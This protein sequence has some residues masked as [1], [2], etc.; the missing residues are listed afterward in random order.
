MINPLPARVPRLRPEQLTDEQRRLYEELLN[1][2]RAQGPQY[3]ELTDADGVLTGPF[4]AML[5]SPRVGTVLQR[6]GVELRYHTDLPDQIRELV[7]LVVAASLGSDFE[8]Y[9]H[10]SLAR[11]YGV[12]DDAIIAL[13]ERRSPTLADPAQGAAYGL[14]VALLRGEDIPDERYYAMVRALGTSG[15]F[16]VSAIVGYY[17]LLAAQL[18]LFRVGLQAPVAGPHHPAP[19]GSRTS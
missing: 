4:N 14:A 8:W 16:D 19:Q 12:D 10:E 13:R 2:P 1:G 11:H 15:V 3:F 18:R 5:A 7:I 17:W 9:A 6:L